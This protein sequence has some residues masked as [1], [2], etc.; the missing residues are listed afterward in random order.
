M[1]KCKHGKSFCCEC[2]YGKYG[3]QRSEE[4]PRDLVD[5]LKTPIGYKLLKTEVWQ[6]NIDQ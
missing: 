4:K 6:E 5:D 3:N 2:A 1:D